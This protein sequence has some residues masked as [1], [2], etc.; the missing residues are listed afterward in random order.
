MDEREKQVTLYITFTSYEDHFKVFS[1]RLER[2]EHRCPTPVEKQGDT[3][4]KEG[5]ER[6]ERDGVDKSGEGKYLGT[7]VEVEAR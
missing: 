2:R 5:R 4:Q 6:E 1:D 3:K 7:Y